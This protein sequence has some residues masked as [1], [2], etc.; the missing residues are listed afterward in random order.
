LLSKY[1][2]NWLFDLR[3][4]FQMSKHP[5]FNSSLFKGK[6]ALITGGGTGI[7]KE[8]VEQLAQLGC[9]KVAICGRR[10]EPLQEAKKELTAKYV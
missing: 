10:E 3:I 9:V 1:F 5:I 2:D 6:V 8:V 7:G 4:C